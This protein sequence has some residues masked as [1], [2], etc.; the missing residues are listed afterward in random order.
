MNA[1][2]LDGFFEDEFEDDVMRALARPVSVLANLWSG[3]LVDALQGA[4]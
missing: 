3:S 2:W 4:G 1:I